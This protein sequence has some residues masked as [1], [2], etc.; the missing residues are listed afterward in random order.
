MTVKRA[1]ISAMVAML[2]VSSPMT[3]MA[4]GLDNHG[5]SSAPVSANSAEYNNTETSGNSDAAQMLQDSQTAKTEAADAVSA[6]AQA[7]G[8][9]DQATEASA[10]AVKDAQSAKHTRRQRHRQLQQHSRQLIKRRRRQTM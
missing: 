5:T 10:A 8:N 9:A 6:A 4:S 1:I 3:A 2:V 7:A